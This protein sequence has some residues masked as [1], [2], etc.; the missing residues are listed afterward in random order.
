MK[1]VLGA[2]LCGFVAA[3][4]SLAACDLGQQRAEVRCKN[5]PESKGFKC[6]VKH[7]KGTKTL[8]VCW[9]L[10]IACTEGAERK[11]NV[12]QDVDGGKTVTRDVPYTAFNVEGCTP[13]GLEVK[14]LKLTVKK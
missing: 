14:N 7:T 13:K 10:V 12:C 6:E 4:L 5:Q 8:K 2:T 11:T 1:K 9:D 3:S